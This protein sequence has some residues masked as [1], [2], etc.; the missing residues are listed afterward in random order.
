MRRK[1]GN[2]KPQ[3]CTSE[4]WHAVNQDNLNLV[5]PCPLFIIIYENTL[6]LKRCPE[7]YI[8]CWEEK[9]R[10]SIKESV[11][12]LLLGPIVSITVIL[13]IYESPQETKALFLSKDWDWR[14]DN[15]KFVMFESIYHNLKNCFI[16]A[17]LGMY[18]I[19][20]NLSVSIHSTLTEFVQK[21]DKKRC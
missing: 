10:L 2:V 1:I 11:L 15:N 16:S 3:N 14:F 5:A 21:V 17:L 13:L 6:F 8:F 19:I 7:K 9:L 12:F 4:D 18:C 20:R